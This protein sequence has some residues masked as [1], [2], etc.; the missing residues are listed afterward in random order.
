M[1]KITFYSEGG[2]GNLLF[3]FANTFNLS[4]LYNL[5]L[6]AYKNNRN[7][8]QGD[9]KRKLIDDYDI[10]KNFKILY[11]D[12]TYLNFFKINENGFKYQNI[13]L[14]NK[15]NYNLHGYYQSHKYFWKNFDDFK[16]LLINP[17]A[18]SINDYINNLKQTYS[19]IPIISVHFRRTDYLK[20]PNY[21]LN[22]DI[23]YY[24]R[25]LEYFDKTNSIFIFFSDDIE[26]VKSQNFDIL[27]NKIYIEEPSDEY[28]LW[29]MSKCDHNI[30]ANSS[31]SLWASYLNENLNKKVIC[32][33]KWFGSA[34]PAHNIN[35]IGL[36]N[37]II[38]NV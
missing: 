15:K 27:K 38:V 19:N 36:D 10:F 33:N 34:G 17:F 13:V 37:Y 7:N 31:F 4:L 24:I 28:N 2:L 35:D 9:A 32:P 16:K 25:A 11:D 21:H 5:E 12:N 20:H 18:N 1:N 29:L 30:I 26:W 3:M 14:D 8:Y 23:N 22:L 6:I